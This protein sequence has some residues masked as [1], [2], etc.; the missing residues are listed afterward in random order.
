MEYYS[1][2]WRRERY[3]VCGTSWRIAV[4]DEKYKCGCKCAEHST[5]NT[6]DTK[7][8]SDHSPAV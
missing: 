3:V 7:L 4:R 2:E 5:E 8:N 6:P 1:V